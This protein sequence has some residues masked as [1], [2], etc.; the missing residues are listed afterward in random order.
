M[1]VHK[2][3]FTRNDRKENQN[4]YHIWVGDR[5]VKGGEEIE[6]ILLDINID[7]DSVDED[8]CATCDLPIYEAKCLVIALCTALGPHDIPDGARAIIEI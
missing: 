3:K 5:C 7:R 8:E 1:G 6:T 4:T 2:I